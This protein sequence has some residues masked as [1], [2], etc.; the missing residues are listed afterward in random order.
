MPMKWMCVWIATRKETTFFHYKCVMLYKITQWT[1]CH[2]NCNWCMTFYYKNHILVGLQRTLSQ[3]PWNLTGF[4]MVD[5][6]KINSQNREPP[7]LSAVPTQKLEGNSKP[8]LLNPWKINKDDR[9]DNDVP[10]EV[11]IKMTVPK[12]EFH[13]QIILMI[14]YMKAYT[15]FVAVTHNGLTNNYKE[16]ASLLNG[17][18]GCKRP[19]LKG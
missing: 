2:H 14:I 1:I 6:P 18:N 16:Q 8:K 5:E 4:T 10:V 3:V 19:C 12:K 11:K 17:C 7:T 13:W 9:I 15:R